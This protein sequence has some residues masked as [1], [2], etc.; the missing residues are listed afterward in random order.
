LGWI[1]FL[2]AYHRTDLSASGPLTVFVAN[3]AGSIR[4]TCWEDPAASGWSDFEVDHITLRHSARF[5]PG[6]AWRLQAHS[7]VLDV[8]LAHWLALVAHQGLWGLALGWRWAKF[9]SSLA[10]R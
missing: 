2:S 6:F 8:W 3:E 1:W 10:P 5:F 4:L 9:R 7:G